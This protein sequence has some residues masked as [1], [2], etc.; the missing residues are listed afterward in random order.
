MQKGYK[1]SAKCVRRYDYRLLEAARREFGSWRQALLAAGLD[2]QRAGF[3]SA[4]FRRFSKDQVLGVLQ[5]WG[6]AGHS[7][8]WCKI[9][10]E[11]RSLAV[12]CRGRFGSWRQALVAAGIVAEA[13]PSKHKRKWDQQ[14][15][16]DH[17]HRR[18][19]EGKPL[20]YKAIRRDDGGLL[21]AA[22]RY[23]G[24]WNQALAA[25]GVAVKPRVQ[26]RVEHS[27]NPAG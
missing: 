6:T 18:Q 27:Q 22:K 14:R 5:E 11:N 15:I 1:P 7:L 3:G 8:R 12:A 23:F 10:L 2:L 4:K 17:I 21:H 25:A 24:G 20:H 26:P 19:Q 16:I 13:A 9:C